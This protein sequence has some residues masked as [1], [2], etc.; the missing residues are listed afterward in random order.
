MFCMPAVRRGAHPQAQAWGGGQR[1]HGG[2]GGPG[3]LIQHQGSSLS[4]TIPTSPKYTSP[5][6]HSYLHTD[7]HVKMSHIVKLQV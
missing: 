7:I 5:Q 4:H 2:E 1:P 6:T 3:K